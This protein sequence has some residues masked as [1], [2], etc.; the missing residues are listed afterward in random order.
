MPNILIIPV[1]LFFL[2]TARESGAEPETGIKFSYN[3]SIIQQTMFGNKVDCEKML[4]GFSG[5]FFIDAKPDT[6]SLIVE[7]LY[8]RRGSDERR[9]YSVETGPMNETEYVRGYSKTILH[10]ISL[11]V[12]LKVKF[13]H[14][15][16]FCLIM[17]PSFDCVFKVK[18]EFEY[19]GGPLGCNFGHTAY[20]NILLCGIIGLRLEDFFGP[21][22]KPIFE[23]RYVIGISDAIRAR[24]ENARG[25]LHS[26]DVAFGL[27]FKPLKGKPS[28]NR[29]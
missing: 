3:T 2:L 1:L 17:G 11:P 10:C 6:F 20:R 18:R 24:V 8:T 29:R 13:S 25:T 28:S 9:T 5:G 4:S 19:T 15:V 22:V 16:P 14:R 21:R 7:F 26:I 27:K 23:T 12:L